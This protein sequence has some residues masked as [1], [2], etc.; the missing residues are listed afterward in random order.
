M[1]HLALQTANTISPLRTDQWSTPLLVMAGVLATAFVLATAA[2]LA[3][4]RFKCG[5]CSPLLA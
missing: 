1:K 3:L 5:Q 2:A 4:L